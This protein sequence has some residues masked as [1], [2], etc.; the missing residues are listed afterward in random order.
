MKTLWRQAELREQFVANG[1]HAVAAFSIENMYAQTVA[2]LT[3]L[4]S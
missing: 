1:R 3:E 4:F 2:L